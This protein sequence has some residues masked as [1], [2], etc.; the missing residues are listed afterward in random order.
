MTNRSDQELISS[1]Q[2]VGALLT[3]LVVALPAGTSA[4][5]NGVFYCRNKG[6]EPRLLAT[7]F[8]DD[9]VCG[10]Q[11]LQLLLCQRVSSSFCCAQG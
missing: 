2:H 3:L 6:H 10:E 5:P 1:D 11:Q 9:G 4:C 7:S 8:V